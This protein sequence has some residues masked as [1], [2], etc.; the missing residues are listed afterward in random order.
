MDKLGDDFCCG[1]NEKDYKPDTCR[2]A[3][4]NY[5]YFSLTNGGTCKCDNDYATLKRKYP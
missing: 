2:R 1:P 5:K 4:E 3:C